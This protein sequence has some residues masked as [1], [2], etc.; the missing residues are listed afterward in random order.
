MCILY[1][2]SIQYPF[3][4][5]KRNRAHQAETHGS[6]LLQGSAAG[7]RSPLEASNSEEEVRLGLFNWKMLTLITLRDRPCHPHLVEG[8]EH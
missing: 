4:C 3:V 6:L 5:H 1:H 8:E 2:P 7:D